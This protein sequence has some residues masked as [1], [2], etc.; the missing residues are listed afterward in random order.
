MIRPLRTESLFRHTG[1]GERAER[2]LDRG[3]ACL[4][5]TR[6]KRLVPVA[7]SSSCMVGRRR[8]EERNASLRRLSDRKNRKLLPR[9]QK[10]RCGAVRPVR[11]EMCG[12]LAAWPFNPG[13]DY[14]SFDDAPFCLWELDFGGVHLV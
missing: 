9:Q 4:F 3:R 7:E 5:A 13:S 11:G 6:T 2:F 10:R 14:F 8:A 1:T 12:K